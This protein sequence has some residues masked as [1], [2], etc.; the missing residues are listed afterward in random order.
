MTIPA[1]A[2][3]AG[4]NQITLLATNPARGRAETIRFIQNPNE[5][6]PPAL[7]GVAIGVNDYSLHRRADTVGIRSFGDLVRAA[8]DAAAFQKTVLTY[9]GQEKQFPDRRCPALARCHG[10]SADLARLAGGIEEAAGGG[11]GPAG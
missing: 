11:E 2:F 5:V 6:G 9:R 8:E 1:S 3:R 10:R 7:H 4:D